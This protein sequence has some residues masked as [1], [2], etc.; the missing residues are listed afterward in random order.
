[1]AEF[2]RSLVGRVHS[3]VSNR[4]FAPRCV[5]RLDA[6]LSLCVSLGNAGSKMKE[7]EKL[8]LDGYT[9]DISRTGLALILPSVRIGGQYLTEQN[10]TLDITLK[11]PNGF[12]Q[13]QAAPVRYNQLDKGE[14]DA[15][16]LVGTLITEMD[17]PDR[18]RYDTY[19]D[20]L[21]T[22]A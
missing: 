3:F 19:L 2:L 21:M 7:I 11:L 14:T 9:R 15:G 18:A 13:L 6:G 20:S 10:Q 1:M 8:R 16:Y 17:A 5:T 22:K 12:I 4:R